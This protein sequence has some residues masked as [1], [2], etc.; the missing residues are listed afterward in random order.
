MAN[1]DCMFFLLLNELLNY[2]IIVN[3]TCNIV[4]Y[5]ELLEYEIVYI[6]LIHLTIFLHYYTVYR[7]NGSPSDRKD[8]TH[9]PVLY[10]SGCCE[11]KI[12]IYIYIVK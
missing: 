9:C 6:F 7:S 8:S 3:Y 1:D 10:S 2:D 12:A 4:Y 5:L 11:Y